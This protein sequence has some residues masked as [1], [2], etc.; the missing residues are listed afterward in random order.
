MTLNYPVVGVTQKIHDK[1]WNHQILNP[2]PLSGPKVSVC[3][4]NIKRL[5]TKRVNPFLLSRLHINL[6]KNE[7]Q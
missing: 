1:N 2:R 5:T 3:G 4:L 7:K 6:R